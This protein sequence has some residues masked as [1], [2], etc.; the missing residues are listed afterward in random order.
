MKLYEIENAN[1][2]TI[3]FLFYVI[4]DTKERATELAIKK[5]YTI[6]RAGK[7]FE[8]KDIYVDVVCEDTAKEYVSEIIHE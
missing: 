3:N 1:L 8:P 4:A 2:S 6:K 7:R 5:I